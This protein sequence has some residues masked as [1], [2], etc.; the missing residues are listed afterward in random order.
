[1]SDIDINSNYTRVIIYE[2]LKIYPG[3]QLLGE[4]SSGAKIFL[5]LFN[6]H[7]FKKTYITWFMT[8][9]AN[10]FTILCQMNKAFDCKFFYVFFAKQRKQLVSINLNIAWLDTNSLNI[11]QMAAKVPD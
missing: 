1:M 10:Y 8:I 7:W 11:K 2:L 6:F 4:S 3:W 5:E 9:R